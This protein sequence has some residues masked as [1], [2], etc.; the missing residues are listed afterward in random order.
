MEMMLVMEFLHTWVL[1]PLKYQDMLTVWI[2]KSNKFKF[3]CMSAAVNDSMD[4][5]CTLEKQ[6]KWKERIIVV[7]F[8]KFP[9]LFANSR[10]FYFVQHNR[11]CVSG[12]LLLGISL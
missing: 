11:I 4:K 1:A 9:F 12:A 2:N 7:L 5:S 6:I 3:Y 8:V 10:N